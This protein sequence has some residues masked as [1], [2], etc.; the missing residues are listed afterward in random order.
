VAGL[1]MKMGGGFGGVSTTDPSSYGTQQSYDTVTAAA[2]GPG[3]TVP[4]DSAGQAMHP[5]SPVGMAMWVG[6]AAVAALVFIR[7]SLPN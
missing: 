1:S 2:F 3:V 5:G 7:Y 6:V 4:V